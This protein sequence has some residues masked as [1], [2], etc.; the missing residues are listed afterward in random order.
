MTP[1]SSIRFRRV[2]A[3]FS[4]FLKNQTDG[5]RQS[6]LRIH[7][8]LSRLG[9]LGGILM[10]LEGCC[11]SIPFEKPKGITLEAITI[12]AAPCANHNAPT[13]L[14][15][16]IVYD[17]TLSDALHKMQAEEYF[18]RI[19]Q[20]RYDNRDLIYIWRWEITPGEIIRNFSPPAN[21]DKAWGAFVF[22]RYPNAGDHRA[23][24]GSEMK[25]VTIT[26]KGTEMEIAQTPLSQ[27]PPCDQEP[28][29]KPEAKHAKAPPLK[30]L[31]APCPPPQ[32]GDCLP[33]YPQG[34]VVILNQST[35]ENGLIERD[36]LRTT[37]PKSL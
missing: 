25:A 16:A 15:L 6:G 22:A 32:L 30:C 35:P 36:Y 2:H 14:D 37:L 31:T 5:L 21:K 18:S 17:Q 23:S 19:E 26:L 9:A 1:M 8:H 3:R 12:M 13:T 29:Q 7:L 27:T 24:L 20:L 10:L 28:P 11:P 33:P 34:K 4:R